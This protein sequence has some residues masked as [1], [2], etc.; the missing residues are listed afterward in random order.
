M[1]ARKSTLCLMELLLPSE[2]AMS[3]LWAWPAQPDAGL[4][5]KSHLPPALP[6]QQAPLGSAFCCSPGLS[7]GT[8]VLSSP[9]LGWAALPV[10]CAQQ[11]QHFA[12]RCMKGEKDLTQRSLHGAPEPLAFPQAWSGTCSEQGTR[13]HPSGLHDCFSGAR[14]SGTMTCLATSCLDDQ[15]K[16]IHCHQ[17]HPAPHGLPRPSRLQRCKEL[18]GHSGLNA[19]VLLC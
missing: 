3:A 4:T 8:W 6:Q 12:R 9:L 11:Q 2:H 19:P 5:S 18:W 7:D 10:G 17:A 13:K 1:S 14:S 15:S 16:K